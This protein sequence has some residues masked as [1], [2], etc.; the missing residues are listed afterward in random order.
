MDNKFKI[1]GKEYIAKKFD[2]NLMCD[3]EDMGVDVTERK[4]NKIIRAYFAICAGLTDE[5]AGNEINSHIISGNTLEEFTEVMTKE[6]EKSDFF[7][8]VL[9]RT[10]KEAST[11]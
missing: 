3:L 9:K 10:E 8:A 7:Q 2:F 4:S 6:M 5:E 11:N 1:N